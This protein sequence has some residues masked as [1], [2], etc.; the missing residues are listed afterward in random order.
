MA[1]T[2]KTTTVKKEE[3]EDL[4]IPKGGVN[5]DPNFFVSVNGKNFI[6]PKGKTSNVPSYVAAEYRRACAEQEHGEEKSD[7]LLERSKEPIYR[8]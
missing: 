1:E 7:E 5:E 4:F 8:I 6:L 3:R 2:T